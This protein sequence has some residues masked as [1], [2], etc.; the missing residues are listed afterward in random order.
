MAE[1][2]RLRLMTSARQGGQKGERGR[3]GDLT[4]LE[5]IPISSDLLSNFILIKSFREILLDYLPLWR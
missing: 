1:D 3:F 2:G 4:I 5:I